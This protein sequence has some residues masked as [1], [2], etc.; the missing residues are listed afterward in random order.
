MPRP[1]TGAA[2]R[3]AFDYI[4]ASA[5]HPPHRR[6]D[7][8]Y[9][10]DNAVGQQRIVR[11]AAR[12]PRRADSV[13]DAADR[14]D[15]D[16]GQHQPRAVD[17]PLVDRTLEPGVEPGGVADGRVAGGERLSQDFGGAQGA[18]RLRLVDAPAPR[19]IVAVHRQMVMDIDQPR[20]DRHAGHVDDLGAGRP[21]AARPRL[22]RLDLLVADHN[23]GLDW[24]GPGPVDQPAASEHPDH[25]RPPYRR[26]P[27]K[28]EQRAICNSAVRGWRCGPRLSGVG[29][30]YAS[31]SS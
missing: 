21:V 14:R 5:H 23:R 18:R 12:K 19:Q 15:N 24:P 10:V 29:A 27:I 16:Q 22:D 9:A 28:P 2:G 6:P 4:G 20:Q 8:A 13:A 25:R 3:G 17:Q 31:A 7:I 30:G 1:R 11:H 26:W